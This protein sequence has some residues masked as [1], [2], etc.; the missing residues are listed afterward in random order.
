MACLPIARVA[1]RR[2]RSF[3]GQQRAALDLHR[4]RATHQRRGAGRLSF[5]HVARAGSLPG[6]V[7][8][9]SFLSY[10]VAPDVEHGALRI[11][12]AEHEL[13]PRPVSVIYPHA[14]LLPARTRAFIA[15]MRE[16][17]AG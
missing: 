17:L 14:R 11:V 13:P 1:Q 5:N 6:W 4:R 15:M 7:G 8:F 10:Q 9:G 12:L 16:A 2:V 3:C